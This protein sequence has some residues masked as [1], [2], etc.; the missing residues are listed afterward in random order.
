LNRVELSSK[1]G[2]LERKGWIWEQLDGSKMNE[3][4]FW[5]ET[6]QEKISDKYEIN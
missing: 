1:Q 6:E 4:D 3:D 5:S 2:A